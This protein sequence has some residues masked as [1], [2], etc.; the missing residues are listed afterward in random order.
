MFSTAPRGAGRPLER[1]A[2]RVWSPV[3]E[4]RTLRV[5]WRSNAVFSG[6]RTL[7]GAPL[8][9]V[10]RAGRRRPLQAAFTW[11]TLHW[12]DSSMVATGGRCRAPPGAPHLW[13]SC[14]LVLAGLLCTRCASQSAPSPLSPYAGIDFTPPSACRTSRARAHLLLCTYLCSKRADTEH[15]SLFSHPPQTHLSCV[16][17]HIRPSSWTRPTTRALLLATT[18][19]LRLCPTAFSRD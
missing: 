4:Q 6:R 17:R 18:R 7:T 19:T 15:C 8:G 3:S 12:V 14:L 16:S 9:T 13:R 10:Q 2:T 1:G 5:A 11:L